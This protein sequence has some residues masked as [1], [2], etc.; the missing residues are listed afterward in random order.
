MAN[1]GERDKID[2][3]VVRILR[4]LGLNPSSLALLQ[5]TASPE[6]KAM[7]GKRERIGRAWSFVALGLSMLAWYYSVITPEPNFLY[8]SVLLAGFVFFGLLA[9]LELFVLSLRRKVITCLLA[10]LAFGIAERFSYLAQSKRIADKVAAKNAADSKDTYRHLTGELDYQ[11]SDDP[12]RSEFAFVNGGDT[13]II[14]TDI[15]AFPRSFHAAEDVVFKTYA[16][17][18]YGRGESHRIRDGGDGQTSPFLEQLL[19]GVKF[20]CADLTVSMKYHL[21][22]QSKEEAKEFRFVSRWY[23][24]GMRWRQEDVESQTDFCEQRA[25]QAPYGNT[26]RNGQ[27]AWSA[28]PGES[29]IPDYTVTLPSSGV[30]GAWTCENKDYG[31]YTAHDQ[32]SVQQAINDVEACRTQANKAMLLLIPPGVYSGKG[33]VIPQTS[34]GRAT[35]WIVVRSTEHNKIVGH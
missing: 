28:S 5:K 2:M 4:K 20:A 6:Q 8:T 30:G 11:E 19:G 13:P 27:S 34:N 26:I 29:F 31:P 21:E 7:Q 24:H 12:M 23:P 18:M 10:L 33:I 32:A 3:E 9:L 16:F 22:T 14:V 17:C 35:K 15:C 1:T 25:F